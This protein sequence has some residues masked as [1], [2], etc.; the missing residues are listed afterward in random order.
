KLPGYRD[1]LEPP[2]YDRLQIVSA[3]AATQSTELRTRFFLH[4]D[5]RAAISGQLLPACCIPTK[6]MWAGKVR[7]C[8]ETCIPCQQGIAENFSRRHM[9]TWL[10]DHIP[11]RWQG[12][13]LQGLADSFCE[14]VVAE[15][16]YRHIRP[17]RKGQVHELP[18]R[19]AGIPKTV[20]C[21]QHRS[22]VARAPA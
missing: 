2:E 6:I 9:R 12:N 16:E 7:Y 1:H 19:Q 13:R 8:D 15:D 14:G 17:Q 11:A 18:A 10:N 4:H 3:K 22:G 5:F 21:Q 20:Q